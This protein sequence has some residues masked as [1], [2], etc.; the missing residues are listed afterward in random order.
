MI[1]DGVDISE[2]QFDPTA[3]RET[4]DATFTARQ[5]QEKHVYLH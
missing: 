4:I 2:M 5:L 3:G 1:C